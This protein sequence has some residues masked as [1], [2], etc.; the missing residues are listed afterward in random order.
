[1]KFNSTL[2]LVSEEY[3]R[4]VDRH[5]D[6]QGVDNGMK[7]LNKQ[8]EDLKLRVFEEDYIGMQREAIQVCAMAIRFLTDCIK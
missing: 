7:I 8:V 6:F 1:M 2:N 4:A 3:W 5:K